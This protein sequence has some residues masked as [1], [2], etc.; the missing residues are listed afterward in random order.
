MDQEQKQSGR[1][2]DLTRRK[3]MRD[4]AAAAAGLTVGLGA[5]RRSY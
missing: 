2:N 3:F 4:G 1:A 5:C